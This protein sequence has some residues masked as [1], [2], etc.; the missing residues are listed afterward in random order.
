[1]GVVVVYVLRDLGNRHKGSR[2]AVPWN[3]IDRRMVDHS[4]A[5]TLATTAARVLDVLNHTGFGM[6]RAYRNQLAQVQGMSHTAALNPVYRIVVDVRMVQL[7]QQDEQHFHCHRRTRSAAGMTG[8]RMRG[9]PVILQSVP[10]THR[11]DDGNRGCKRASEGGSSGL[12]N[13]N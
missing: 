12:D 13:S 10:Q 2:A 5:N 9:E 6:N 4:L 7:P 11:V 3:R 1:V 8:R